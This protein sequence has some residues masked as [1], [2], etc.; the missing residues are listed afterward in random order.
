MIVNK[1][2]ER[3]RAC[4]CVKCGENV[5]PNWIVNLFGLNFVLSLKSEFQC[6]MPSLELFCDQYEWF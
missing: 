4:Y 6:R 5:A 1:F 2:H 3:S